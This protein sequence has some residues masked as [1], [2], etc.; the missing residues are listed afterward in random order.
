[1]V[2]CEKD[3][4]K[5]DQ[6][7]VDALISSSKEYILENEV[8][9][10][11]VKGIK[12]G[13]VFM[14]YELLK[15]LAAQ[16]DGPEKLRIERSRVDMCKGPKLSNGKRR[17]DLNIDRINTRSQQA[18]IR[19]ATLLNSLNMGLAFKPIR[20]SS[21][22][23][24]SRITFYSRNFGDGSIGEGVFPRNG[25]VG[26]TITLGRDFSRN[27]IHEIGHNLG[28]RHS[29][30]TGRVTCPVGPNRF[31]EN[32]ANTFFVFPNDPT[33]GMNK[34]SIMCACC[35]VEQR[36]TNRDRNAFR[37]GYPIATA[38]ACR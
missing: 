17:I 25:N 9:G 36:M 13:D 15:E 19:A 3:E 7:E 2:S 18:V 26:H 16:K 23:A 6:S 37:R 5:N 28:F 31:V 30:W 12:E 21:G 8:E 14:S 27:I 33:N 4:T 24:G 29:D 20:G 35:D 11:P 22:T 34:N 38:R 32:V 10:A 1:M